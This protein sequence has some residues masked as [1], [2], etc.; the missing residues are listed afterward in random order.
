MS[1]NSSLIDFL[2]QVPIF[3]ELSSQELAIAHRYMNTIELKKGQ[4]LFTEGDAGTYTCFVVEGSLEVVKR[5]DAQIESVAIATLSAGR[6]IGE[7]SIID[8]LQRSATVQ[9]ITPSV[10]IALSKS[11]FDL[12]LDKHPYIG[13][14][15]LKGIARLISL[16]L[17]K[18]S[19]N[20]ADVVLPLSNPK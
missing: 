8:N 6:S 9:A 2:I 20:L 14:K 13:I 7:M 5:K 1:V 17:R 3:D 10:L 4:T 19:A 15:I 18:T 12:I 11:N 16:N